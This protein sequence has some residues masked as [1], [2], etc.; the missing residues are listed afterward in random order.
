M[1]FT[2]A[3]LTE[4][5]RRHRA[6]DPI[7]VARKMGFPDNRSDADYV[8]VTNSGQVYEFE[9]K[10]SRADFLR[11][12]HKHRF[13]VYEGKRKGRKPNR[14]FYVTAPGIIEEKDLPKWA[15]WIE[16]N[17]HLG[18]VVQRQAPVLWKGKHDVKLI[19]RLARAMRERGDAW[20]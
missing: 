12:R 5:I 10:C 18:L 9:I 11:D 6:K 3:T 1:E 7:G 4:S 19:L 15:G 2:H 16:F 14:F 17:P 13:K 8:T 20:Q